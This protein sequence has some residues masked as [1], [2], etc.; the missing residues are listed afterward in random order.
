MPV[1]DVSLSRKVDSPPLFL[2]VKKYILRVLRME[3]IFLSRNW[4]F[5]RKLDVLSLPRKFIWIKSVAS[6]IL[7]FE[8][9]IQN[10]CRFDHFGEIHLL[11]CD[12]F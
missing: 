9:V 5:S 7:N 1:G 10:P 4:Y 11:N 2:R 12:G 8:I 3:N 6:S